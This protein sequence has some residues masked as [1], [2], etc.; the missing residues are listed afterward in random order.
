MSTSGQDPS[1]GDRDPAQMS[2]KKRGP[3]T[4]LVSARAG[5]GTLGMNIVR[6]DQTQ[7]T[8]YQDVKEQNPLIGTKP[9]RKPDQEYYSSRP[10]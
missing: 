7:Q 4:S 2:T 1:G 3:M 10:P 9:N 5:V 6:Y 8:F